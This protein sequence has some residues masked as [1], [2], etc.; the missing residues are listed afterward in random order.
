VYE[1]IVYTYAAS[2]L[3][4]ILFA[5]LHILKMQVEHTNYNSSENFVALTPPTYRL[6]N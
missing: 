6:L 1:V 3:N 2:V 4:V 5:T